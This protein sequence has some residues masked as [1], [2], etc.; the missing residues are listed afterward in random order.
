MPEDVLL[1]LVVHLDCLS[2][3][4]SAAPR[5]VCLQELLCPPE[6]SVDYIESVLHLFLSVY[7]SFKI[8]LHLEVYICLQE[9]VLHLC[10]SGYQSFV[11]HL[12]LCVYNLQEFC[13]APGCV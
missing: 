12:C 10:I 13:A 3:R 1:Q 5:L 4:A 7:K 2:T 9:P 11:L 8:V 6:V